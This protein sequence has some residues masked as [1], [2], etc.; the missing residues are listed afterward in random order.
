MTDQDSRL[1]G[2]PIDRRRFLGWAGS[3]G[4]ALGVAGVGLPAVLAACGDDDDPAIG[5]PG[6]AD[7]TTTSVEQATEEARAVVGDVVDFALTSDEWAGAFGFV[8][9]RLRAGAFDGND[10]YFVRTDAS[11]QD[12]ASAE[13]LI[14]VPKLA[15]LTGE[16]LSGAA[17]VVEGG[18][19]DQPVIFSSEP[20]RDDYTPAWTLHRVTWT[21][22]PRLLRSEPEVVNAETAG[23]VT[24]ERTDIV[25]NAGI[26]KWS[27][28][29]MAVDEEKTSYLGQGQ[30]LEPVDTAAMTATFKLSQ[31]YPASRYFVL[32]HSMA[33]MAE[34]T[35]TSFSPR[36]QQGPSQSGATG[37]TNV[38]M[39]GVEGP[40]PMGFQ[41]SAFDFD[42]GNPAWSPY[43]DHYA[44]AWRDGAEPRVLRSQTEIHEAR[45]AGELDEFPGVPDTNGEVF[46]VNCP[47]PILAPPTFE[48][49]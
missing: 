27:N 30:L 3:R 7:G 37:R 14:Y 10:V 15:T 6:S 13:E 5:G 26:V 32:D 20:G 22:Q 25:V 36:L 45:D 8:T 29:E 47:V 12:F 39:N 1:A 49:G 4:V 16:G 41:P 40:G 38:F 2:V 46:T 33:P 34:M 23:E 48:P 11:D 44:Y 18:A 42:A 19:A 28:G 9:M 31:C 35:F 17:Y 24:V 43:W 21:G